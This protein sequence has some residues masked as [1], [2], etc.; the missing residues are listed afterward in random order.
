MDRGGENGFPDLC[1]GDAIHR[2]LRGVAESLGVEE[3]DDAVAAELD[4]RDSLSH[5]RS[6]FNVP[7][8]L[9]DGERDN[10]I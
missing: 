2:Y 5:M 7:P 6:S 4:F 8:L 1:T 9:K 10:G 3:D